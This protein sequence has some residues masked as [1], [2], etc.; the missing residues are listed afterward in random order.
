MIDSNSQNKQDTNPKQKFEDL[1]FGSRLTI[2]KQRFINKDGS[3][4]ISREGRT[5]KNFYQDLVEMSWR[6]FF[7]VVLLFFVTVNCFFAFLF[8]ILGVENFAGITKGSYL[9]DFANLFY[10]SIQTF[11]AVG[12]GTLSPI[13]NLANILTSLNALV[14][15]M[16][17]A[18]AT[19]LFFAR[20]SKPKAQIIFSKKAII[21]PHKEWTAFQFRIV[22]MSSSKIINLE[23]QVNLTWLEK[24]NGKLVR[25]FSNLT[26]ERNHVFLFPLNWT[27]VHVIDPKSPLYGKT[28]DELKNDFVEFLILLTGHNE[29]YAQTIHSNSSYISDEIVWN[30]KFSIMYHSEKSKGTVLTLDKIDDM[31]PIDSIDSREGNES[32]R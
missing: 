9:Q 6:K 22:N 28:P 30:Q 32:F 26:L 14:G 25:R 24:K 21:R 27:L 16:A 3:F 10:L 15:L 23:A 5:I 8:L 7:L 19:G 17:L 2:P 18:L 1:G 12:Y 4:N 11:T 13:S 20:F 29:T 31:E